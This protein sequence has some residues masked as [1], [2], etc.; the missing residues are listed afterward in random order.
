MVYVGL[1]DKNQALTWLEKN[2]ESR[3]GESA[4]ISWY[5]GFESLRGEPRYQSLIRQMEQKP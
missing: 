2:L 1:G 4:R 5:P 3:S